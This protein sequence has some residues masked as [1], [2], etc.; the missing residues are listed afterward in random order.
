MLAVEWLTRQEASTSAMLSLLTR[1]GAGAEEEGGS[2][3]NLPTQQAVI[4][5]ESCAHCAHT[6]LLLCSYRTHTVPILVIAAVDA[7][8]VEAMA[9]LDYQGCD[10]LASLYYAAMCG[11]LAAMAWL[12]EVKGMCTD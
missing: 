9:R 6:V 8:D 4:A 3:E 1:Q 5:G 10:A 2:V 11:K 7:D 12:V